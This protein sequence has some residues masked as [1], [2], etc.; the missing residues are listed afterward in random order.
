[1]ERR[2][3]RRMIIVAMNRA[4]AVIPPMIPPTV[5]P[6]VDLWL[7]P[8]PCNPGIDEI[9]PDGVEVE[10]SEELICS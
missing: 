3:L 10:D 9:K 6:N 1:M 8:S 5:A 2:R 4:S 7:P